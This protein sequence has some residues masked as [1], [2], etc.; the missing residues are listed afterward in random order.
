VRPLLGD[1]AGE[2]DGQI[3]A[4]ELWALLHG[5]SAL[6]MDRFAPFDLVRV[7]NAVMTLIEGARMLQ[8]ASPRRRSMN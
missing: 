8:S 7:T 1:N 6:Y 5:M 4:D 2:A 3:L